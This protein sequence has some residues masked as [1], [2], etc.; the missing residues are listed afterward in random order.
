MSSAWFIVL[1][2]FSL[3]CL[4]ELRGFPSDF[5]FIS[6]ESS[7][8][9][10]P[11][12]WIP[13]SSPLWFQSFLLSLLYVLFISLSCLFSLVS[14][15]LNCSELFLCVLFK[16]LVT[17]DEAYG[18]LNSISWSSSRWFLLTNIPIGPVGL[19]KKIL[20]W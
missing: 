1:G 20:V 6:V 16:L 9:F 2:R 13:F 18:S 19:G 8:M 12:C 15:F 11:P 7:S 4:D 17:A 3:H 14:F 10:L 5:F